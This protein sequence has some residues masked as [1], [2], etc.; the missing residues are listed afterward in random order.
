MSR[1]RMVLPAH[2]R[3]LAGAGSEVQLEINGEPTLRAALDALEA[4]YP[5]L[6]GTIRD[7]VTQQRRPFLRFFACSE[8]ISH[9]SPDQPLPEAVI[10]GKEPLLIIGAIAGGSDAGPK[11]SI[12]P[13]L[14]VRNGARA[15]EFYKQAFGAGEL[16]RIDDEASGAVVARLSVEGAEFWVADESP[17]HQNFSPETVGCGTVRIVMIVSD[18]DAGFARAIAAGAREVWPVANQYGWR[19]GRVVDPFGHHWEIGKPLE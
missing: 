3:N 19:L 14:N 15:V 1:I 5:M 13:M 7:H 16:F 4:A 9:E 2:L 12:A 11:T 18:P 17:E 6:R 8:D 10:A